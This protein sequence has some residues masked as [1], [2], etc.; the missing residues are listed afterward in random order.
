MHVG[1]AAV[2]HSGPHFIQFAIP[3]PDALQTQMIHNGD[4]LDAPLT[5]TAAQLCPSV[6]TSS[7]LNASLK[8]QCGPPLVQWRRPFDSAPPFQL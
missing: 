5:K 3:S 2:L 1:A 6:G 8:E 4:D 7:E